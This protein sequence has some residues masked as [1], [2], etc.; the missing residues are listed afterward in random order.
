MD[1]KTGMQFLY[2]AF[3]GGSVAALAALLLTPLSGE[4]ARKKLQE[5]MRHLASGS[6]EVTKSIKHTARQAARSIPALKAPKARKHR[7][8]G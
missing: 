7:N 4:E 5:K 8:S 6:Q 2:G 1:T 3:L